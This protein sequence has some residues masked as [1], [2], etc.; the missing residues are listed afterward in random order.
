MKIALMAAMIIGGGTLLAGEAAAE[1]GD[2]AETAAPWAGIYVGAHAAYHHG[3]KIDDGGCIG[4]CARDHKV[5]EPYLALQA[6]YDVHVGD[7]VVIGAMAWLGVTPVKSQA[8]LSPTVVVKGKTDF[9]GFAGIRLGLDR[10]SLLPYAFVGYERVTGTVT[11][12]AAPIKKNKGKH[13]GVG[14]GVGAEYRLARHWS[15]DGRYM[16]SD[17]GKD[18][19]DFGGGKTR[20]GEQA[21]TLS[22]GVN[23]RF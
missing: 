16:Y 13:E 9:A 4:L 10:G 19:Y 12:D 3:E 15:M 5:K 14:L 21:H 7:D 2:G 6:G 20:H 22:L 1:P 17:L 23:F 18:D 8:R 11:N